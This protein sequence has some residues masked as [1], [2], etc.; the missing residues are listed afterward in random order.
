[1]IIMG[2]NDVLVYTEE[3]KIKASS[4]CCRDLGVQNLFGDCFFWKAESL[5]DRKNVMLGRTI[6]N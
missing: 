2:N 3:P 5:S 6:I 1:M 4:I